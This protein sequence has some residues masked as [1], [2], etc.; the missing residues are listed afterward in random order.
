MPVN[1]EHSTDYTNATDSYRSCV[2]SILKVKGA[3]KFFIGVTSDPEEQLARDTEEF[4]MKN[5]YIISPP[6]STQRKTESLH[7]K[8]LNRFGKQKTCVNE[9]EFSDS[10]K[11]DYQGLDDN[12]QQI[13]LL[14]R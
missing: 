5:M 9:L 2:N 4:R 7:K 12:E 8:L 1:T 14:I 11:L 13:Y 6:A 10:G 3:K